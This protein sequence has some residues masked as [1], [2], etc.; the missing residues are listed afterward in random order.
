VQT[1]IS[2]LFILHKYSPCGHA[3]KKEIAKVFTT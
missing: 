1:S 2:H 3:H